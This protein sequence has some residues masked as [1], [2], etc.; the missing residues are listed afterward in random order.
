MLLSVV[1]P[2]NQAGTSAGLSTALV[3]TAKL[4]K[5][6]P[7]LQGELQTVFGIHQVVEIK[8]ENSLVHTKGLG[9]PTT[10]IEI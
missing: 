6:G 5:F 4:F 3:P 9:L 1:N 8:V 7:T 2:V 10:T